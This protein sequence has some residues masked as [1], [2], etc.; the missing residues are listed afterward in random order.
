MSLPKSFTVGSVSVNAAMA[1]AIEQDEVLSLISSEV[2]QRAAIA[3]RSDIEMGEKV[4]VSMYFSMPSQ[5]K[6]RVAG[7][8]LGRAMHNGTERKVTVADFQGKMVEYNTLLAQLTL[9]N[10]EDFFT[11]LSDAVKDAAPV[12]DVTAP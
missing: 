9:W 3:A 12:P 11:Y 6:Q 5:V 2:I 1:S 7:I 8:L 4:L 10:F